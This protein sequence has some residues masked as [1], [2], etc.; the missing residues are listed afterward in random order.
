LDTLLLDHA[1]CEKKAASTVISLIFRYQQYPEMMGPLSEVAREELE[2]FEQVLELLERRGV[3]FQALPPSPY[4]KQL[5]GHV[6]SSEPEQFLDRLLC[7]SLIEARSCERMKLL[8]EGLPEPELRAFYEGLLVSEARH[9]HFY[10]DLALRYF[11]RDLVRQ[12]LQ[13]LALAEAEIVSA[14]SEEP[15]MHS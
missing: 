1:H 9:H 11:D 6:R 3:R 5:A 14:G 15:R 8:S 12:R 13:E 7:C 4:A 10:V 2:H